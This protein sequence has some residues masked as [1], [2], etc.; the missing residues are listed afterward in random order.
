[1]SDPDQS[2]ALTTRAKDYAKLWNLSGA[3]HL[4]R[5]PT[6]LLHCVT[7]ADGTRAVL[8]CLTDVGQRAEQSAPAVLRAFNGAGAVRLLRS[9]K[10]AHLIEYCD[11]RE[12]LQLENGHQDAIAMPILASVLAR[13]RT[14]VGTRP[15]HVTTLAH[16]CKAIDR[17]RPQLGRAEAAVFDHAR[18]LADTLLV[19][20]K[21]ALLHGDFHHS[22]VVRA[23]RDDRRCWLALDP[24]GL[25]GDP[26][27]DVANLFG[28]PLQRPEIPL[29]KTR[30]KQLA[31]Y[32][33]QKL[34]LAEP[35]ILGWAFVHSC[36]SAAWSIEDGHD[37]SFRL[38]VARHIQSSL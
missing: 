18:Q 2:N 26:A 15:A 14:H 20:Q 22:N 13:L 36:I 3:R 30:P 23:T 35:R 38:A 12:V 6:G 27:Y 8:K 7:C 31:G 25:W 37:P 9:D 29:S 28:N 4:A 24:Q 32:L 16:R 1:M 33:S 34:G 5:T 11:G 10:G 19:D 17:A 21:P